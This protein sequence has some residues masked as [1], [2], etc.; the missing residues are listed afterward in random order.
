M[1]SIL[2][3]RSVVLLKEENNLAPNL[4]LIHDGYGKIEAYIELAKQVNIG[5]NIWGIIPSDYDS[6]HPINISIEEIAEKHINTIKNIQSEG[7]Y[8]LAGWCA[9]GIIAYEI[10]R[11]LVATKNQVDFIAVIDA[12]P[13][14]LIKEKK[15]LNIDSEI[16]FIKSYLPGQLEITKPNDIKELWDNVVNNISESEF[17]YLLNVFWENTNLKFPFKKT[18]VLEI[19]KCINLSRSLEVAQLNYL[20]KNKLKMPVYHFIAIDGRTLNMKFWDTYCCENPIYYE[21]KGNHNSILKK[22]NIMYIVNKLEAL[23]TSKCIG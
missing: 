12:I 4:F 17:Q 16:D 1:S 5:F 11:K 7:P 21:V 2:K 13:P 10:V 18:Y 14:G 15:E 19:L 8:Y 23:L 6:I 3:N 9:G 20:P 22:S